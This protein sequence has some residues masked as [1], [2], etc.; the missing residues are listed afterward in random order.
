MRSHFRSKR[1]TSGGRFHHS[2]EKRKYELIGNAMMTKLAETKLKVQRTLGGHQ[3]SKLLTCNEVNVVKDGKM[4]KTKIMNVS[5][6]PADKHLARRNIMTKG[7]IIDTE[8]GKAR[9]TSRPGQHGVVNAV[10]VKK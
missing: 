10:L 6:N 4:V 2:R 5:D 9:I 7:A 3:K 8:F 1:K